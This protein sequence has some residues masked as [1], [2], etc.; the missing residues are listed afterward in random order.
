V[1][2]RA[3]LTEGEADHGER[4]QQSREPV[5]EA[6]H[7]CE[8]IRA[9]SEG[10]FV[11]VAGADRPLDGPKV[12]PPYEGSNRG[13]VKG[14]PREW[15]EAGSAPSSSGLS[16]PSLG[17]D[18]ASALPRRP[19]RSVPG[20]RRRHLPFSWHLPGFFRNPA[21]FFRGSPS[22]ACRHRRVFQRPGR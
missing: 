19:D 2:P 7:T 4:H 10:Q 14:D 12:D 21:G 5:H 8:P 17:T 22:G 1:E 6:L 3:S 20:A 16:P 15:L 11:P 13:K 18:R 9:Q